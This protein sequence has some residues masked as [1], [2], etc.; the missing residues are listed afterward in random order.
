MK[1]K[2]KVVILTEGQVK[3]LMGNLRVERD[4]RVLSEIKNQVPKGK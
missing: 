1:S 3:S 4:K 2:K